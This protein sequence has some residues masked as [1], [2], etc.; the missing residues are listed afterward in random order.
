[1][2]NAQKINYLLH[3]ERNNQIFEF[4]NQQHQRNYHI[5]SV[6]R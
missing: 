4:Q 1:M 3:L 6:T 5:F 2:A